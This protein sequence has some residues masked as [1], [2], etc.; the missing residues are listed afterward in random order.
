[1]HGVVSQVSQRAVVLKKKT[2]RTS[3]SILY[4]GMRCTGM[5]RKA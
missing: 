3:M 1:M 5:M 4:R 2:V